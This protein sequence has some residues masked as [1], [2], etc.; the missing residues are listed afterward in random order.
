MRDELLAEGYPV[1]SYFIHLK[2]VEANSSTVGESMH[3][4]SSP[5]VADT[6]ELSIWDDY[7]AT[8]YHFVIIDRH[9][10]VANHFGPVV[11]SHFDGE[12]NVIRQ[13]WI[14]SLSS[15]CPGLPGGDDIGPELPDTSAPDA[16]PKDV[17]EDGDSL[18]LDSF[19]EV[20]DSISEDTSDL[21]SVQEEVSDSGDFTSGVD[22]SLGDIANADGTG[23]EPAE[24]CQVVGTDPIELGDQVPDFLCVDS[25]PESA[26]YKGTFSS[27][28]MKGKVW[29]AYFGSCT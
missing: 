15:E 20:M 6:D 1:T 27:D 8:W 7:L 24:F 22:T 12:Q 3:W 26:S 16:F 29:L 25:N 10:C 9:G 11:P 21:P 18:I 17:V 2:T 4:S 13:A 23:V 5:V 28:G 14:D 19:L